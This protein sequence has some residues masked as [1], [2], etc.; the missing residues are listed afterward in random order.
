MLSFVAAGTN[1]DLVAV[2][3]WSRIAPITPLRYGHVAADAAEDASEVGQ[4][5]AALASAGE[6]DF[7]FKVLT[8]LRLVRRMLK[9]EACQSCDM[10]TCPLSPA[11]SP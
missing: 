5:S 1:F 4:I 6:V 9:V 2:A 7:E 11:S 10:K 8:P 3:N